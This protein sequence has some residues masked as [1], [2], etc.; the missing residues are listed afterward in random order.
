MAKLWRADIHNRQATWRPVIT[1]AGVNP[2]EADFMSLIVDLNGPRWI[3]A[4]GHVG[5]LEPDLF[6]CDPDSSIVCDRED[7]LLGTSLGWMCSPGRQASPFA[8]DERLCGA[9]GDGFYLDR[10]ARLCRPCPKGC[11]SCS[12]T[13]CFQCQAPLLTEQAPAGGG[14][15]CVSACSPGFTELAGVCQRNAGPSATL[16]SLTERPTI[17]S[18]SS[19]GL[20]ILALGSTHLTLDPRD[21]GTP[22]LSARALSTP[23]AAREGVLFFIPDARTLW[24]PAAAASDPSRP[25]LEEITLFPGFPSAGVA[26]YTEIGPLLLPSEAVLPFA[27]CTGQ[28]ELLLGALSCSLLPE[29]DGTSRAVCLGVPAPMPQ[30]VVSRPCR[31]V[32]RI[33]DRHVLAYLD[34]NR[35]ALYFFDESWRLLD[36]AGRTQDGLLLPRVLAPVGPRSL[37][38]LGDP[39]DWFVQTNLS[40]QATALP[41]DLLEGD[42]RRQALANRL[43]ASHTV[44]GTPVLLRTAGPHG[45]GRHA[46]EL[47]MTRVLPSGHWEAFSAPGDMLPS[48]RTVDLPTLRH[49]LGQVPIGLG[50]GP[51]R[52]QSLEIDGLPEFPAALL[53]VT[54]RFLAVAFF[55]CLAVAG[56]CSLL[57]ATFLPLG[58]LITGLS[59]MDVIQSPGQPA[60]DPTAILAMALLAKTSLGMVEMRIEYSCPSETFG[61]TCLPCHPSC[62]ECSGPGSDS[63]T[64]CR[65]AMPDDPAICLS[66]CPPGLILDPQ[67]L[68]RCPGSCLRCDPVTG[69]G[70][71][72]RCGMCQAGWAVG[73]PNSTLCQPCH[74]TCLECAV[75]DSMHACTGCRPGTYLHQGSCASA[76]PLGLWPD[77][78]TAEC[79][80]CPA[81]CVSCMSDGMCESCAGGFFLDGNG[82]C[83]RCDASCMA[84]SRA[85]AC[86][87]CRPGLIFLQPDEHV[88]SL[89]GSTCG[90][91]EYPGVDRCAACHESCDLCAE[92]ADMC[93]VCG[94][95]FRW[96]TGPPA[97]GRTGPCVACPAGCASCTADRCYSCAPGLLLSWDGVCLAACPE[98]THGTDESCQPC[99]PSCLACAGPGPDQCTTCAPG[100]ELLEVSA[101][102]GTCESHCPEGQYRDLASGACAACHSACATC[103]GPSDRDCWRCR[104]ALLQDGDCVQH[105]AAKHVAVGDRCLRC[106]ASCDRCAGVR[107]TECLPSCAGGLFALPAGQSPMRCVSSCPVGYSTMGSGCAKCQDHCASCPAS[108]DV[109]ALCDRGWLLESPDCVASCSA[110][111]SPQGNICMVCHDSCG[112]CFGP[113]PGHCLT[114]GDHAPLQMD[115]HCFGTCP[116]GAF[117]AGHECLACSAVCASCSGPRSTDCTGCAPGQA[118]YAGTCLASCPEGH[119]AEGGICRPCDQACRRCD[120]AGSCTACSEPLL[121]QADGEC[122]ASCPAGWLACHPSGRCEP[123]PEHC[124]ECVPAG[125]QC[126]A[127]CQ[128]C[129]PGFQLSDG[130]CVDGCP[131]G[132]FLD[133]SSGICA[134]CQW[135]CLT[136]GKAAERCTACAPDSGHLMPE[137]GTC[138]PACGAGF[139]AVRGVCQACPSGCE[140]C[141]AGPGQ[142]G[143]K[144]AA[145]GTPSCPGVATCDACH[146]GGLLLEGTSCVGVCP[147][148]WYPDRESVPAGCRPCHKGCLECDGPGASDCARAPGSGATRIG[149]AIGLAVGLLVVLVLLAVLAVLCVRHRRRAMMLAKGPDT[150]DATMLN[151]ILE[152]AL[153]G[154]ILVN[155]DMD[156]RRL[157]MT[158][159]AGGQASVYAAQSVGPGI[160][161]RLG[162]PETVAVKRMKAETMRPVDVSLFQNEVALMWL[163]REHRNIVRVYG[164]SEM[165]PAIVM[166]RFD[167]DL[168]TL[169]H[170]AVALTDRQLA[171][172]IR[173][174]ASGMEAMHAH[175]VAHCDLKPANV[176]VRMHDD[177]MWHVALGDLGT[178]RNLSA[179]RSS[180]LVNSFPELNAMSVPYASPEL[181]RAFRQGVPLDRGAF[182]PADIYA[183]GIML[184]ECL[185]RSTSWSGLSMEVIMEAVCQENA[186]PPVE[187]LPAEGPFVHARDLVEAAWQLDA[188]RRPDAGTFRQQCS[189]YFVAAGGLD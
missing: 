109:C 145:D 127:V 30:Y 49:N 178:S 164:Y 42:A 2:M 39:T 100:L 125:A 116:E 188:Q 18:S 161:G 149:L 179:E 186:R 4:V 189:M 143:C 123:C 38:D 7:F 114:C 153:P 131:A 75:P 20:T 78:Q 13:E 135:P 124:A 144:W 182:L 14:V 34:G 90:P 79:R 171:D 102:V 3:L 151:T 40:G 99:D 157:D 142:A 61:P 126:M 26:S 160:I 181:L 19:A 141:T 92:R 147:P 52:F 169:L 15:N 165:P 112:T 74:S 185:T 133:P 64:A 180:A 22:S 95:G 105:C 8:D 50:G 158:L 51:S 91:G 81:G 88:A 159:G 71:G 33:G 156:F 29:P 140:Q 60:Q 128:S 24:M 21:F 48:G 47:I 36:I 55:R 77:D 136:C 163:L 115:T 120:R 122:V 137:S 176:F 72:Y 23:S 113:G 155:V 25:P 130:Q 170:S 183:A 86:E 53:L 82:Q 89:C 45:P 118:L 174:W 104:D 68:C 107:S 101:L 108:R 59:S 134:P 119:F 98:S 46:H 148:G 54:E 117:Q 85:D 5:L 132:E 121:L 175:G 83:A 187:Q 67:A 103:N 162:C 168:K 73:S 31:M 93:Q 166:E 154:A 150:E 56:P 94:D 17:N 97:A 35:A 32:R 172:I 139:A 106:H 63:C 146:A 138:V 177:G 167:T 44:F 6:R 65:A 84:C 28:E 11:T 16:Y 70:G 173:Q 69:P 27:M 41:L 184:W 43:F 76:C 110:G 62:R 12:G 57:P 66:A 87:A 9:C 80:A 37:P 58:R 129:R 152:L 10:P 111:S 1:P 96:A